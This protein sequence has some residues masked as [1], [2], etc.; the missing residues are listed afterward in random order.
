MKK[1]E[2][3]ALAFGKVLKAQRVEAKLS[4]VQL[5]EKAD[6]SIKGLRNLEHGRRSPCFATVIALAHG[7]GLDP[8]EFVKKVMDELKNP[9]E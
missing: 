8:G 1:N 9:K 4:Q 5:I 3:L 2:E 6:L 7:L